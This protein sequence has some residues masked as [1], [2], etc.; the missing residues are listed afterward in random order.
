MGNEF[1]E[2]IEALK[3]LKDYN[4]KIVKALKEIM[5]ELKGDKKEDTDEYLQHILRGINWEIEVI[6][7]TRHYINREEELIS[8]EKVN[9]IILD[10]NET[11][12]KKQ[13]MDMADIMKNRLL[14]FLVSLEAIIEEKI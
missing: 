10:L 8:K 6:N 3:A 14:P 12:Q 1:K 2:E 4:V 13:D 7:G 5:P 11:I 9:Q